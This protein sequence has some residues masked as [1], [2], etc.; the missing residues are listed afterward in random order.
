ML[1]DDILKKLEINNSRSY[2]TFETFILNLLKVHLQKNNKPF[3]SSPRR[4]GFDAFAPEGLEDIKGPTQI[5]I[6]FNVDRY[7]LNRFIDN[8]LNR[9]ILAHIEEFKNLLIITPT[10]ISNRTRHRLEIITE[11]EKPPFDILIWGPEEVN[12]IV[13][14]NRK[15]AND[16]A[17]NLFSLRIESAVT[18]QAVDWKK[19]RESRLEI[20]KNFYQRGQ[21][22]FFLGAG[23]SSSAG[24]PDWNTLLN[25]LF[26]TYLTNEF[27]NELKIGDADINQ[28][29][30]RLNEIDEPSAL[31]A[32][33]YLRKGLDKSDTES[34]EFIKA[35]TKNLYKLRNTKKPIDSKL[36]KAI[37]ELCIPKRTG[38]KVKSVVT[39]NFD[40]LIERQLIKQSIQFHSIYSDDDFNDPDELPVYHVH[41]FLP[42]NENDYEGLDKS[43]LVFSEEGYHLIYSDAYHWSNLVQL[44]NLR[45]N[46]CLMVGL[47]MTD[48]NL[49][50]LLDISSRNTDKTKHFAFMK[51][52]TKEEFTEDKGKKVID[53]ID[54][55]QKFLDRHHNLNEEIMRELGVSIIWYSDYDEIPVLIKQILK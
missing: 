53:N 34:K 37:V 24:M 26:V 44:S 52:I 1:I 21:F 55:A 22:S 38:A 48:P 10:P 6:K 23:V 29:V 54:G 15:E 47:S 11:K 32:A 18:R 39:Y 20:L 4:M 8:I 17:N 28:I 45:D 49:R 9:N 7:P 33:R 12:K 51:R 41:G 30:N 43:T 25:S 27:D 16:I 46:H 36:I 5:E 42:E 19:E 35:I 50:R 2:Y 40:D 31:M 3:D 13:S 14:K